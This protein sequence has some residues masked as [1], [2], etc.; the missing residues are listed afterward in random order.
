MIHQ[1]RGQQTETYQPTRARE[2]RK[3]K[4]Q[5]NLYGGVQMDMTSQQQVDAESLCVSYPE[6]QA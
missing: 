5:K 2:K 1:Q 3:R 6:R 4:T